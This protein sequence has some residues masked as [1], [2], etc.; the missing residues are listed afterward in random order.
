MKREAL[1]RKGKVSCNKEQR[2]GSGG[3]GEGGGD[4]ARGVPGP[5][6]GKGRE[7]GGEDRNVRTEYYYFIRSL[8]RE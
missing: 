3:G 7:G 4:E 8:I 5:Q 1:T 6:E 2:R